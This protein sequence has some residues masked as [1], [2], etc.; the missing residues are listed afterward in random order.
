MSLADYKAAA[1]LVAEHQDS[2]RFTGERPEDLVERA[3]AALGV[4]LPPSY[5]AFARELGAGHIAGEEF[6][7]VTTDDFTKSSV[8]NGIW[9][10]LREREDS[11]LPEALVIAYEDDEGAYYAIDT[12]QQRADGEHP[13]VRW[14]PG[15]SSAH[16]DLEIVAEDFG[17]LFH[18]TVREGLARRGLTSS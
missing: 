16:D 9:L 6:Y 12:T 5:R 3:E 10:T 14:V 1:Q 17:V 4:Q 13:L 2:A 15:S 7:G 11:G 18:E 8:P